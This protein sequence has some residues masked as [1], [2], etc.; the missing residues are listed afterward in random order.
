MSLNLQIALHGR[1]RPLQ[2]PPD[3]TLFEALHI[4]NTAL[5]SASRKFE[6]VVRTLGE[7]EGRRFDWTLGP[8]GVHAW[9][10]QA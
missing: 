2:E 9:E 5:E 8:Y 7:R 3:R 1:V 10:D 6:G 4:R